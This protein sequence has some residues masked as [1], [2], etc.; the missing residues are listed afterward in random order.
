MPRRIAGL[1][2]LVLLGAGTAAALALTRARHAAP[3]A[4]TPAGT[5]TATASPA[6]SR[7]PSSGSG[8]GTVP[9]SGRPLAVSGTV[10]GLVPGRPAALTIEVRNPNPYAVRL[11]SLTTTVGRPDR[12]PCPAGLLRVATAGPRDL[13][14]GSTVTLT[15]PVELADSLTEDQ[16]GCPGA[17]FPLA[18]G[19][20]TG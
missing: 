15:V 2:L 12:S 3:S 14:A 18:F 7:R 4:A 8:S 20:V 17:A 5:G 6:P 11:R 13:P 10:A 19:G 1:L 9:T 16:S